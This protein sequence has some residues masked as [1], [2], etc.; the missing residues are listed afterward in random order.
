MPIVKSP[1]LNSQITAVEQA[2][3]KAMAEMSSSK[4][5][6]I[7]LRKMIFGESGV[8]TDKVQTADGKRIQLMREDGVHYSLAGGSFLM[9][10]VAEYFY[11]DFRIEK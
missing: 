10:K 7:S 11:Q 2:Q 9:S 8:Y 6:R 1:L 4:V 5:R 3:V